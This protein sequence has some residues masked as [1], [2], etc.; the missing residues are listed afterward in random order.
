VDSCANRVC[1]DES[2]FTLIE[3]L[4]TASMLTVILGATLAFLDAGTRAAPRDDERAAVVRD[5]QV[6]LHR[7]TRELRQTTALTSWT[8]T[9]IEADVVTYGGTA[10]VTY[11]CN[12]A[13]P[14]DSALK[15][16]VR[17]SSGVQEVVVDRITSGTFTYTGSP[18]RFAELK[19]VAP[20]RG[21]LR[22]GHTHSVVLS[23]GF[24][25]RNRDV[26]P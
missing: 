11:D 4:L 21:S 7:M 20:A 8:S 9:S 10:H 17:T 3:L 22:E 13:H 24:Y 23:D 26:A 15:R 5:T 1:R 6:G 16:C 14:T 18:P 25:M 2:G 19:V 12:V